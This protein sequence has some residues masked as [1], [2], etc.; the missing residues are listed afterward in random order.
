MGHGRDTVRFLIHCRHARTLARIFR[1]RSDGEG[2]GWGGRRAP[3]G[4]PELSRG[5]EGK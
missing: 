2:V 4:G 5:G 3:W 1:V